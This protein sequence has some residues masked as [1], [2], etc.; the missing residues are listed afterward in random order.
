MLCPFAASETRNTGANCCCTTWK[1][2]RRLYCPAPCRAGATWRRSLCLSGTAEPLL[3][4]ECGR[5]IGAARSYVVEPAGPL[6]E[7]TLF[8]AG[9]GTANE[10]PARL[11][12][13]ARLADDILPHLRALSAAE[14]EAPTHVLV[15]GATG[16]LGAHLLSEL[17]RRT[18]ARLTLLVRAANPEEGRRRV[19]EN[20]ARNRLSPDGMGA[21]VE[22]VTGDLA[23]PDLGLAD[24]EWGR[25]AAE[26]GAVFH[27]AA[28]V[29]WILPYDRLARAVVG[30]TNAILRFA[31]DGRPKA[32]HHISSL[33]ALAQVEGY[34]GFT[35]SPDREHSRG[36]IDARYLRRRGFHLGYVQ[37]KWASDQLVLAAQARGIPA[38]VY[39]MPYIAGSRATGAWHASD[40][41]AASIAGCAQLGFAPDIQVVMDIVPVD[42]VAA[43]VVDLAL[44]ARAVGRNF[45][46]AN[47]EP[48]PWL[49]IIQRLRRRGHRIG[50][51]APERWLERVQASTFGPLLAV[52]SFYEGFPLDRIT[53]GY[54]A[55][56][57][58]PRILAERT[59]NAFV[60]SPEVRCHPAADLLDG[61]LDW[62][63]QAGMLPAETPNPRS[64]G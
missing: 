53:G 10:A 56:N 40:I 12:G 48:I 61:W 30:G 21:R 54:P 43:A 51:E 52:R 2:S 41:V 6:F 34:G 63:H 62:L 36:V 23:S 13:D 58:T 49:D 11:L 22:I 59:T 14:I 5:A 64:D 8:N 24:G 45:H 44:Q 29:N 15:T 16:F 9:A 50:L 26:V 47:P 20:I 37:A 33:A 55:W 7:Q 1:E 32:V 28:P 19:Y 42:Y 4:V 3:A 38:V 17:L 60:R 18:R 35:D 57:R 31:V 25:L 39:R 27:A 46:M